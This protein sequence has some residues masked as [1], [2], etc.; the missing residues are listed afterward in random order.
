MNASNPIKILIIGCSGMLGNTL[1]RYFSDN[2]NFIVRG[3]VRTK[4][5]ASLL[6]SNVRDSIFVGIDADNLG[7]IDELLESFRPDVVINCVGVVKQL[8]S[9]NDPLVSLPINSLFPH[10]L[11]RVCVSSGSRLIHIST[12]CVFTGSKG[13]YCESDIPDARD[14]YGISK[15]LGEVNYPNAITLRTSI[16]G[17]EL[18]GTRSL[19]DWFLSQQE[20]VLGY[21]NAIFSGLPTIE[22]AKL[23]SRYVIPNPHL[24]GIYHVSAEPINKYELLKLIAEVYLKDIEIVNDVDVKIDRSLN[25]SRFRALTGFTPS[26]WLEMVS[27]MRNFG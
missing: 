25:S 4:A 15:F 19:V 24:T 3:T 22:I 1:V 18:S 26:S 16:I 8:S 27:A 17:H 13:M 2:P 6:P 10:R 12:D 20:S 5:A 21:K 7:A 14:M 23:I 9:A 11:A